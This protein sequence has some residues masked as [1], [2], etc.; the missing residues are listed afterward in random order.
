MG[1]EGN[2][3]VSKQLAPVL[4]HTWRERPCPVPGG[5]FS[6][7]HCKFLSIQWVFGFC[8]RKILPELT[9]VPGFLYSVC[10][11]PPQHG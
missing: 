3:W 2:A 1:R 8:V 7:S 10:G 5:A 9:S 6:E 11:I 4:A